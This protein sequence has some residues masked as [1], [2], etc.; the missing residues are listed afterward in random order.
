MRRV[1]LELHDPHWLD[2]RDDPS[3]PCA[4]GAVELSI[5]GVE[6]VSKTEG[7]WTVSAAALF[8]LRTVTSDHG[9]RHSVAEDNFL[10]PCCGFNVWPTAESPFG[11]YIPGCCSGI[12]LTVSHSDGRVDISRDEKSAWTEPVQWAAAVLR[13]S[14]QVV[15]LHRSSSRKEAPH[16]E[17]DR[18]GWALFWQEWEAQRAKATRL[19]AP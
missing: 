7:D 6:L 3:D 10:I 5:G 2:H 9:P 11:Y 15:E 16:D 17:D 14:D 19:V 4:H 13:F 18:E 8:L 12:D 1:V